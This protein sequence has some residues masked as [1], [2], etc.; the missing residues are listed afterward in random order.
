M[1]LL[2]LDYKT[3]VKYQTFREK[4]HG[5]LLVIELSR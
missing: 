3:I 5:I 1:L 2:V 4:F